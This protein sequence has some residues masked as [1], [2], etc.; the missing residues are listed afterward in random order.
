MIQSI[1]LAILS[2]LS[3]SPQ[4][5]PPDYAVSQPP[6][7]FVYNY[8]DD[9]PVFYL[10]G[11]SGDTVFPPTCGATFNFGCTRPRRGTA[12]CPS[13]NSQRISSGCRVGGIA[14]HAEHVNA[15]RL[16]QPLRVVSRPLAP[17]AQRTGNA[18][19]VP[20]RTYQRPGTR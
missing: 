7:V 16:N 5:P 18:F 13:T 15:A 12:V 14:T 3:P 9:Q 1:L 6:A 17:P 11:G 20:Q 2:I 10:N 8:D 19:I 4:T